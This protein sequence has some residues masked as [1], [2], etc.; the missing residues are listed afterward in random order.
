MFRFHFVTCMLY[1]PWSL[2]RRDQLYLFFLPNF[3][4][5]RIDKA[6][7]S[8]HANRCQLLPSHPTPNTPS[9]VTKKRNFS[10]FN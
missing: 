4:G 5:E 1:R 10:L 8:A 7:P 2:R 6:K 9:L 3:R